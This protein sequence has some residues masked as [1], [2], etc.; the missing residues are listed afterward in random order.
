MYLIKDS[1]R[2]ER[3]TL[4]I[5]LILFLN[6]TTDPGCGSS[7]T[8]FTLMKYADYGLIKTVNCIVLRDSIPS[9]IF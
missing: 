7:K 8:T 1:I 4:L 5:E 9:S 6:L 3:E 2:E